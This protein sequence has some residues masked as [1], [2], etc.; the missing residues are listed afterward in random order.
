MRVFKPTYTDRQGK[1]RK[2]DRHHVTF[3]DHKGEMR[4][5]PAFTDERASESLGRKLEAL[6]AA[7][8]M[9]DAITPDLARWI[10]G[11]Q[12]DHRAKLIEWGMIDDRAAQGS[13]PL[14]EHVAD[15]IDDLRNCCKTE[16]HADLLLARVTR[17]FDACKFARYSDI[18]V[19]K[20][21][22]ALMAMRPALAIRTTNHYAGAAK[23]FCRWMEKNGRAMSVPL[24][25]VDKQ[26]ADTDRRYVRRPMSIA[27]MVALVRTTRLSTTVCN[28]AGGPERALIYHLALETGL[29][30][31][32]IRTLTAGM[33]KLDTDR[34]T[35]TVEASN[36][37]NRRVFTFQL[38]SELAAALRLHLASKLPTAR[39]FGIGRYT[40]AM[41]RADLAAAGIDPGPLTARL[42]FHGNRGTF[43]TNL[44]RVGVPLVK[45]QKLARHSDPRLTANF[46][47][48]FDETEMRDAIESLPRINAAG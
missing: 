23:Q 13:R 31:N 3:R 28:K 16:N 26:N 10:D 43:I 38:Q 39:A 36:T 12:K 40:A 7:R 4:R 2:A 11:M 24:A 47:T 18:E 22:A 32:E 48:H 35:L 14:A 41:I 9:N 33:F 42:D 21:N 8:Q 37:K 30:R 15:W 19:V 34:A 20:V 5:L 27:E 17:L 29:R 1:T 44:A 45:S 6:A 46:Y 25:H